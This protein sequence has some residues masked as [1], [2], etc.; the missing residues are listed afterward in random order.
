MRG[1]GLLTVLAYHHDQSAVRDVF[2]GLHS[3]PI[4]KARAAAL[5]KEVRGFKTVSRPNLAPAPPAVTEAI[6]AGT[7]LD[8]ALW[9]LARLDNSAAILVVGE[10]RAWVE[11]ADVNGVKWIFDPA[12]RQPTSQAARLGSRYLA[13][14]VWNG[15]G[16]AKVGERQPQAFGEARVAAAQLN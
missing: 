12:E 1:S 10:D 3:T 11:G 6:Q 8:Q 2:A 13:R 9:L 15:T 14:M 4:T 16:F 7:S 5:L